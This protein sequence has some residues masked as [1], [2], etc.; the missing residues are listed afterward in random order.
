VADSRAGGTSS[1]IEV[2]GILVKEGRQYGTSDYDVGETIGGDCAN[3]LSICS[4]AL[5][6]VRSVSSLF[7]AGYKEDSSSRNWTRRYLLSIRL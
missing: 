4:P 5:A 7:A 1:L 3:A 2:A 6:I